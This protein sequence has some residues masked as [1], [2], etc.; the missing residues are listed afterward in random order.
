MG[1]ECLTLRNEVQG[2]FSDAISKAK[3]ESDSEIAPIA[4]RLIRVNG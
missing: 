4:Q 3:N 1:K 2:H